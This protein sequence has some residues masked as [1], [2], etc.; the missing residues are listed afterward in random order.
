MFAWGP[1]YRGGSSP[2]TR[3]QWQSLTCSSHH[4]SAKVDTT[5]VA[6]GEVSPSSVYS[7]ECH[8]ILFHHFTTSSSQPALELT[9]SNAG[10]SYIPG[11]LHHLKSPRIWAVTIILSVSIYDPR[12]Q[13]TPTHQTFDSWSKSIISKILQILSYLPDLR[14]FSVTALFPSSINLLVLHLKSIKNLPPLTVFYYHPLE[15][16]PF[17]ESFL[18]FLQI[19]PRFLPIFSHPPLFCFITSVPP[20]MLSMVGV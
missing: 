16:E 20:D 3:K 6:W 4:P 15:S 10:M 5:L 8:L 12:S 9:R 18:T 13:P 19:I 11:Y 7:W 14:V 1:M 17:S 2:G